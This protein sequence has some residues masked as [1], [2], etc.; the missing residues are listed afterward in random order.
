MLQCIHFPLL[1]RM[2]LFR[3]LDISKHLT[4]IYII[5]KNITIEKVCSYCYFYQQNYMIETNCSDEF[6]YFIKIKI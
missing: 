2:T 1:P 3:I 5:I 6:K 4:H